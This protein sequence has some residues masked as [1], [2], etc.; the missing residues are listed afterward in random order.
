MTIYSHPQTQMS[1]YI[2]GKGVDVLRIRAPA[3]GQETGPEIENKGRGLMYSTIG[4]VHGINND[5]TEEELSRAAAEWRERTAHHDETLG[6]N[7]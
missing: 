1:T 6:E 4:P 5:R 2:D 3:E 7:V